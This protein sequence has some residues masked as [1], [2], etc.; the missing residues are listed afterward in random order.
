MHVLQVCNVGSIVGGTAACAWSITRAWPQLRHSVAFLSPVDS[1]TRQAFRPHKVAVWP[2]CTSKQIEQLQPDLVILHNVAGAGASH[3]SGA[4][5]VQYVHS[6]GQRLSADFTVYCS[7]WLARQCRAS[8]ESVLWQG[9]PLPPRP[10]ASKTK[11]PGR[12][13]IGRI[14]TPSNRKWPDSLPA[15]YS[16]LAKQHVDVDWDFV[17]CPSAMQPCLQSA[18]QGRATF[19]PAGWLARSHLWDWDAFLYHHP[20]LTES[21]GRTLAEAARVGCIPIVDQRGGFAEQLAVVGGRGC[22]HEAE[23]SDAISELSDPESRLRLSEHVHRQANQ[24]FSISAFSQ[25][26]GSLIARIA[27]DRSDR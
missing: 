2:L 12:F 4:L 26:L 5:T 1:V 22:R 25:R 13:R 14:C 18:C 17:G 16:Q 3:W 24:M 27:G 15:F 8:E 7:R 20:T 23:F 9:V 11:I 21:F 19:L 10:A 6:M